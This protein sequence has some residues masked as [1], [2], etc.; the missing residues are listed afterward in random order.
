MEYL[1][2]GIVLVFLLLLVV[3]AVTGRVNLRS[4]CSIADP[5]RDMRMRAAFETESRPP[6]PGDRRGHSR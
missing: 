3:G 4:C 5:S 2:G 6:E 1:L